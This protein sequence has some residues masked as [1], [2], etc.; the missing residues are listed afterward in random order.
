LLNDLSEEAVW[1]LEK[2]CSRFE[3]SWLSC[4][5]EQ[6]GQRPR[7]EDFLGNLE[8]IERLAVIRELV[9][10]D[11]DYR[12]QAG[13]SP[14][15][16]EYASRFPD[17]VDLLREAFSRVPQDGAAARS[18][19]PQGTDDVPLRRGT[20]L[21]PCPTREDLRRLLSDEGAV[22]P[23]AE[24]IEA[25]LQACPACQKTLE[26]LTAAGQGVLPA[27]PREIATIPPAVG[28]GPA[29]M[30]RLL[31]NLPAPAAMADGAEAQKSRAPGGDAA[32][33]EARELPEVP[34]YEVLGLL[35]QGGMGVVYPA[36]Q[37]GLGRVV[38]L[39][40]ILHAEYAGDDERRRFQ[41]EAEAVA[42]LQHPNIIQ[43]YEVGERAGLPYFSL[44]FCPGGS[45]GDQLDGTPWEAEREAPL[46][47]TLARAM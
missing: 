34:G 44:E 25:H 17:A 45:L 26:E 37:V 33:G 46:V 14:T 6:T 15:V 3:E 32:P 31:E 12:R 8:G 5:R 19:S 38:A 36:R 42:T 1:R 2:A 11:L 30:Q 4:A 29:F 41:A 23:E 10:L 9:L 21:A 16:A 28:V 18:L 40:M 22:G 20:P 39:K 27:C 47:E 24:V 43:I 13:E 7:P 35:G